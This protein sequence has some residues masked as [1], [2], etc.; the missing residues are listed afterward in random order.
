MSLAVAEELPIEG[1]LLPSKQI[2]P[3]PIAR[4]QRLVALSYDIDPRHM[5]SP[6]RWRS[7]TWPRQV[8]MY[9]ARKTTW[10]SLT[11]I[12]RAFGYRDHTTV[13]WAIKAVEKRMAS[14]PI[15]HADVVALREALF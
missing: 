15:Y 8:A 14:D 12:G 10:Q 13:I 11:A 2:E 5:R 1:I 7:V 3:R 6:C 4:I 9:L